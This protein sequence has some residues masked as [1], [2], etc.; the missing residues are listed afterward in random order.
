V[1][2]ARSFRRGNDVSVSRIPDNGAQLE[3]KGEP[4]REKYQRPDVAAQRLRGRVSLHYPRHGPVR[5]VRAGQLPRL[6]TRHGR[7]QGGAR[8]VQHGCVQERR[9]GDEQG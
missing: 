6:R 8:P 9:A 3:R 4:Q 5:S 2:V 1:V 7:A